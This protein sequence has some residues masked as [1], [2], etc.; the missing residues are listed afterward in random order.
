[1]RWGY[2]LYI[3]CIEMLVLETALIILQ[4]VEYF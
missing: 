1:V 2:Q 4:I 3:T